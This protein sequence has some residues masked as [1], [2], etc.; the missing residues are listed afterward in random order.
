MSFLKKVGTKRKK[1]ENGPVLYAS[2]VSK[3]TRENQRVRRLRGLVVDYP[4]VTNVRSPPH[5]SLSSEA[6]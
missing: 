1:K 5:L 3:R 4:A 2:K 6:N